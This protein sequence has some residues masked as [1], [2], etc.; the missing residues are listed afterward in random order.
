MY[1][2]SISDLI[3]FLAERGDI[4]E[5]EEFRIYK[6]EEAPIKKRVAYPCL[7]KAA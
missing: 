4:K 7:R 5:T 2:L 1:T 3:H 6:I